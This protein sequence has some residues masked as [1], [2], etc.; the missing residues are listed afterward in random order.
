VLAVDA[1]SP[2]GRLPNDA[3]IV[4][5][6]PMTDGSLVTRTVLAKV[7]EER[8]TQTAETNVLEQL[9]A[10]EPVLAAYVSDRLVGV[11]G[12]LALSGAPSEV[13]RSCYNDL[14]E[15]VN[16]TAR[17]IWK[18]HDE[19]W[20]DIDLTALCRHRRWRARRPPKTQGE[21]R[22]ASPSVG[23]DPDTPSSDTGSAR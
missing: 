23:H 4:D 15:V 3:E 2:P 14:L 13:V 9:A 11:S 5:E 18:G 16:I 1:R 12:S 10:R 20:K 17:A 6:R 22:V 19:F 7:L 21:S 8:S